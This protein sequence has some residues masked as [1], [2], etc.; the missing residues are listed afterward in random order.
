MTKVNVFI[1]QPMH[2]KTDYEIA[3]DRRRAEEYVRSRIEHGNT[4][5][6][7]LDSIFD[8]YGENP[9]RLLGRSVSVLADADIVLMAKGWKN[10]RGCLVEHEVAKQYNICIMEEQ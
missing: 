5:V 8:G 7:I 2:G 1:S 3:Y 6:V 4:E 10:A 9:I